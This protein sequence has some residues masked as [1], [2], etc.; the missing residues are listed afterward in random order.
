MASQIIDDGFKHSLIVYEDMQSR[1]LRLH[2]AVWEGELRQCPV[3][4]AFG[5]LSPPPL[6]FTD[7]AVVRNIWSQILTVTYLPVTHQSQSS[8]WLSRRSR[9][10]VW[11]KDIQL[12]V[13]CNTYRQEH[14]RQN[15]SGAFE[16]HFDREEGM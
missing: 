10:R 1:G 9:H 16:I 13:F 6:C 8:T 5:W 14:M 7:P 15:K 4:T 11:L 12:Y 3:W 2:A